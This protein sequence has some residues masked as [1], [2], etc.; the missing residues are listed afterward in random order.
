MSKSFGERILF[1]NVQFLIQYQDRVAIV[2]ANGTGKS[3]LLHMVLDNNGSEN[4]KVGSNVKI[5]YLS[6][7]MVFS[8]PHQK[9]I[10]VFRDEV[11]VPE[12]D[13]R[14]LLARFLFYGAAVFR[15]VGQL[16]GGERMRLRLAQLMHQEVN[17]FVLDEPTNHLDIESREVLEE[18]LEDFGGTILAVS[19]DRFFLNKL[20]DRTFW[21][22]NQQLQIWEGNYDLA[23]RKRNE[24]QD[25][26]SVVTEKMVPKKK[27][28]HSTSIT[29]EDQIKSIQKIEKEIEE[30]EGRLQELDLLMSKETQIE[31]IQRWYEKKKELESLRERKYGEWEIMT[32]QSS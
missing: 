13:A 5:G 22:E 19:H 8:D 1:E 27:L 7:H 24:K 2:G 14:H 21:I 31:E 11:Q 4:L 15:E 20:F 32:E 16:S 28:R 29:H 26:K 17:L 6:Q 18:A 9:V 30:L 25:D 12:G 23:K 10:D 3:T